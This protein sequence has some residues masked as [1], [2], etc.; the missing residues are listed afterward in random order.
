M[1]RHLCTNCKGRSYAGGAA[2]PKAEATMCACAR[3]RQASDMQ[4]VR[5]LVLQAPRRPR[6]GALLERPIAML[7]VA[8]GASRLRAA[9]AGAAVVHAIVRTATDQ[10]AQALAASSAD[11]LCLRHALPC[12]VGAPPGADP[13]L[14]HA[15]AEI[16]PPILP[17][18]GVAGGG[19][20]RT[21]LEAAHV[22]RTRRRWLDHGRVAGLAGGEWAAEDLGNPV[23]AEHAGAQ[24]RG[25][26]GGVG[27]NAASH[28]ARW[29][30]GRGTGGLD[31]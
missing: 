29:C 30:V 6:A 7:G 28:V 27:N 17:G 26:G 3:M 11:M 14:V 31:S 21:D 12:A 9:V 1:P 13:A 10:V 15:V 19:G 2:G 25:G 18:A 22:L 16:R 23:V 24:N 8:I 20:Q 4:F 5:C